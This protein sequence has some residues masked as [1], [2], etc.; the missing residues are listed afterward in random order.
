MNCKYYINDAN[1]SFSIKMC[2]TVVVFHIITW[3]PYTILCMWTV[4]GDPSTV[5]WLR[6][7]APIFAKTSTI[8]NPFIYF[9][10]NKRLRAALWSWSLGRDSAILPH[11]AVIE[12]HVN[13]EGWTRRW[14]RG[15]AVRPLSQQTCGGAT[16][17]CLYC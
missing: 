1:F 10:T 9:M 8:V 12:Y 11:P 16:N 17:V 6:L 14:S 4:I 2:G 7:A 13:V 3:L 15:P 5:P